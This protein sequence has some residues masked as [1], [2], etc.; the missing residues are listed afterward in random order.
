MKLPLFSTS[1][2][3]QHYNQTVWGFIPAHQ[4]VITL[5]QRVGQKLISVPL[6]FSSPVKYLLLGDKKD[7]VANVVRRRPPI[8]V[9]EAAAPA[10]LT[11]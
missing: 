8:S 5:K 7:A 6:L 10:V 9:D 4:S 3:M 2:K 1:A 11:H